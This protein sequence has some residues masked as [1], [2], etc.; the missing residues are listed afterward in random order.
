MRIIN[1]ENNEV[2]VNYFLHRQLIGIHN[3][4]LSYLINLTNVL[5]NRVNNKKL[6]Q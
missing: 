6:C 1:N 2:T 3:I 5:N 4:K